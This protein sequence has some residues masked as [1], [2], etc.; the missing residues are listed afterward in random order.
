MLFGLHYNFF[1]EFI[2]CYRHINLA[3]KFSIIFFSLQET[4]DDRICSLGTV[5][6]VFSVRCRWTKIN[7]FF[8]YFNL[9]ES[10]KDV[11]TLLC[12]N[13]HEAQPLTMIHQ[14]RNLRNH[15][16]AWRTWELAL[17]RN[18][19]KKYPGQPTFSLKYAT[20]SWAATTPAAFTFL[21]LI[22]NREVIVLLF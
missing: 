7:P 16:S 10:A 12:Y 4:D 8:F 2:R 22:C 9:D 18:D 19:L 20:G 11:T 5:N 13:A 15:G 1:L 3:L 17:T 6:D 21:P 14:R